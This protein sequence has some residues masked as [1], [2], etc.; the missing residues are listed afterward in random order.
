V[1]RNLV[2]PSEIPW[3]ELRGEALE[4]LVYWLC[5]SI[6]AV[7]L[8]WRAGSASGTSRDRGRDIEATFHVE[9][10]GGGFRSEHWWVQVKGRSR[11]VE[12]QTV[13]EALVDAQ[14]NADVA[15]LVIA[16]NSRFS[17][18][19]RDWVSEFQ[20]KNPRP[21]IKLWDRSQLE[22]MVV[23]HPSVVARIAPQALSLQGSLEA[24]S[25]AFWNQKRW[26]EPAQLQAFWE[27]RGELKFSS[28]AIVAC[29]VGDAAVD[30][31]LDHPWGGECVEDSLSGALVTGLANSGQLLVGF[32]RLGKQPR[33]LADGLAHLLACS[34]IRLP[35][36]FIL[37]FLRDPWAFALDS[38]PMDEGL[39][40]M[41]IDPILGRVI[42]Y[43]GAACVAD[44][45][46]VS[47]D[48]D[49]RSEMPLED[50]WLTL[51]PARYKVQE[52]IGDTFMIFEDQDE[53]CRAGLSLGSER[54]CPFVAGLDRPWEE[55]IPELQSVIASRIGQRVAAEG[56]ADAPGASESAGQS[57]IA[58][59]E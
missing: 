51:V 7:D 4:E 13:K 5:D 57:E 37:K 50:R 42:D 17:N 48:F 20:R 49:A 3:P 6:G 44:C 56:T 16:T 9:E 33:V 29:V 54:S 31:L 45:P 34:M 19:T 35:A 41:T 36:G 11:T 43:F 18:D 23:R 14:G 39:R 40:R 55:L 12:P 46:R 27:Q 10:P 8:F 32:Q 26:P 30:G 59:A 22:R 24:A 21:V 38:E 2:I 1:D 15:V 53:P 52:A 25:E 47:A 28:W 58:G